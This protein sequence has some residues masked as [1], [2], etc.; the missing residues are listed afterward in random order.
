[1]RVVSIYQ[2]LSD[3]DNPEEIV[4]NGPFPCERTNAWFGVGYYFWEAFIDNAH[5]WGEQGYNSKYVICEAKCDLDPTKI[6][7]LVVNTDDILLF[8]DWTNELEKQG[9]VNST[10]SVARILHYIKECASSFDYEAI[11]GYGINSISNKQTKIVFRR[12]FD[13]SK[14]QYLDLSPAIQL[15]IF[16]KTGLNLRNFKIVHPSKYI[17]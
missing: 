9:L 5:W 15:C 8:R 17:S 14:P 1:L 7:D 4:K 3:K 13:P 11:R 10:T 6:L 12:L 2:T 16:E